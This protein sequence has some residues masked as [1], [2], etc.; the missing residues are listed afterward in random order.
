MMINRIFKRFKRKSSSFCFLST[1]LVISKSKVFFYELLNENTN[2]GKNTILESRAFIRVTDGGR[3]SIGQ[4]CNISSDVSIIVKGGVV[5]IRDNVFIGKGSVIVSNDLIVIGSDSQVAE[6]CTIRDQDHNI[7][8]IPIRNSGMVTAPITIGKDCWL[9]A[10]VTVTKSVEIGNHSVVGANS[11]V[12][13]NIPEKE[14][15]CGSP[16]K[17]IKSRLVQ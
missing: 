11:V 1:R 17:R 12:T 14:V 6:Y 16:A 7:K 5:T 15:F 4:N 9:G 13:K 2:I 8:N 10:K 3:L